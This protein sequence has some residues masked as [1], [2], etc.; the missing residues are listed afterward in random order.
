MSPH[1]SDFEPER[2][3]GSTA[4]TISANSF[5][6]AS[7]A[8]RWRSISARVHKAPGVSSTI[9]ANSSCRPIGAALVARG[10]ALEERPRQMAPLSKVEPRVT[11]VSLSGGERLD[12]L[13]R[14]RRRG[15]DRLRLVAEPQA[16]HRLI[17]GVGLAPGGELVAPQLHVLLAAQP[18]RLLGRE[19]LAHRAVRPFE[20]RR[21]AAKKRGRSSRR[22][23]ARMPDSP[24]HHDVAHVGDGRADQ[25][26][27]RVGLHPV[28]HRLGAGARLAGAAAGEDEP[29]DPVARRRRLVGARPERPVVEESARIRARRSSPASGRA[30]RAEI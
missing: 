14:A 7:G 22:Q 23:Q 11:I 26:D 17:E 12:D 20:P 9:S 10:D 4:T 8:T 21:S 29:D 28:A 2:A 18:V 6:A 19:E 25:V 27:D 3:G 1:S 30:W 13:G 24:L 16:Q 5:G 15:D